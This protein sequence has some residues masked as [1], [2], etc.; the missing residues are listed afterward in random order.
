[1]E[2]QSFYMWKFAH[3]WAA[4]KSKGKIAHWK[5]SKTAEDDSVKKCGD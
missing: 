5:E 2:K 4:A 3:F 1:M